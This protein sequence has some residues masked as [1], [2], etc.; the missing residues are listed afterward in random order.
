ME[1]F[2]EFVFDLLINH[3]NDF[4]DIVQDKGIISHMKTTRE[5]DDKTYDLILNHLLDNSESIEEYAI[6]HEGGDPLIYDDGIWH[7]TLRTYLGW[8]YWLKP[9]GETHGLYSS[10]EEAIKDSFYIG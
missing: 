8:Y 6:S 7:T 10:L 2:E 1:R 5:I 3:L 4:Y 9:E